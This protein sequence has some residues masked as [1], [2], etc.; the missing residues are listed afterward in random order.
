MEKQFTT[1]VTI[2][3]TIIYRKGVY[4]YSYYYRHDTNHKSL[5]GVFKR[6]IVDL[7]HAEM[8]AIGAALVDMKQELR[9]YDIKG[10][11]IYTDCSRAI[12]TLNQFVEKGFVPTSD[13]NL[14]YV[15]GLNT[16]LGSLDTRYIYAHKQKYEPQEWLKTAIIKKIEKALE[17]PKKTS[18]FT[19]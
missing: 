18:K 4:G 5:T 1:W 14:S 9:D 12:S 13:T 6:G 17:V 16:L 2:Y 11:T 10:I 19:K 8:A 3:T 15:I 7:P